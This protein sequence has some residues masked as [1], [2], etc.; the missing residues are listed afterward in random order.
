M[1]KDMGPWA[2][3]HSTSYQRQFVK[4]AALGRPHWK[5]IQAQFSREPATSCCKKSKSPVSPW[6]PFD[7]WCLGDRSQSLWV[8]KD[9]LPESSLSCT[10]K[11][12]AGT[13]WHH[14]AHWSWPCSPAATD[15]HS[16]PFLATN[17]WQKPWHAHECLGCHLQHVQ[18]GNYGSKPRDPQFGM[19]KNSRNDQVCGSISDN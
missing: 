15:F 9:Y 13:C 10:W 7:R 19:V 14:L 2:L 11:I 12:I 4:Y 8:T 5:G 18:V 1:R 3:P 17:S 6:W 16:G